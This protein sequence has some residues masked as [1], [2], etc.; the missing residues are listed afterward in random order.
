M[1][2]FN[3]TKTPMNTLAD[4]VNM[5]GGKAYSRDFEMEVATVV[6]NSMINGDSYYESEKARLARIE[7]MI[8]GNPEKAEFL[9]KAMVYTRNTGNLRSVAHY[10]GALLTEN[11]KGVPFMKAALAKT[12]VRPDDATEMVALWNDRNSGKMVP[13]ALRKAIKVSLENRWD[14]YQLRKYFGNGSVKV[15]NLINI[16]HPKPSNDEKRDMFKQAL[17]GRL[18]AIMTAQTVNAGTKGES[19]A[20]AYDTMLREGKLG[21]MAA[22]KNIRNILEAGATDET[23]NLL[24]NLLVNKRAVAKSRVLPFRFV[25]AYLT[26]DDMSMDRLRA[27]RVLAAIDK[28]F[29]LSAKNVPIVSEGE[30]VAI[31]LDES[32]SMG[33]KGSA[34]NGMSYFGLGKTLMAS[35]LTGLD[36]GSTLGYLWADTARE[37]S[38]DGS[39]MEFWKRTHTQGYGT[40]VYA[41]IQHLVKTKTKVDKLVIITDMQ[42]YSVRGYGREFKDMVKEY[43][44]INPKVKVL[45]W[46][47]AGYRGGTPM[48]LD[49]DILEVAG[50]S[51]KMLEVIAKMWVD[52]DALI[53]EIEA[54]EL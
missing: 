30:S 2:K 3:K 52:K 44:K 50:F 18:P 35:M 16:A 34:G 21:Y 29:E 47:V 14:A 37:V 41:A 26:V 45:F 10:M 32:G 36:K 25:Q 24:C 13:N 43:R 49:H 27:K 23:V 28:G 54:V 31:L 4:S 19:R 20:D 15:S 8:V 33:S 22:L 5:A 38:I 12:M 46:N 17:E 40:D 51:D 9:A 39:P 6:L 11:V 7:A 53:K 48:K 42:M 1:G